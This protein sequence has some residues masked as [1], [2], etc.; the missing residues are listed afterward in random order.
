MKYS[1]EQDD[2][3]WLPIV[4]RSDDPELVGDLMMHLPKYLEMLQVL[5]YVAMKHV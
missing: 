2:I 5:H 3:I 4:I 1:S